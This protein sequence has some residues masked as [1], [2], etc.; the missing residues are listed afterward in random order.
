MNDILKSAI[1]Y[2]DAGLC[3]IPT[4]AD[5]RPVLKEWTTYQKNPPT[6]AQVK[7]WFS[8]GKRNIAAVCGAVSNLEVL[9]F[10]FKAEALKEWSQTVLEQAPGLFSKLIFEKSPKGAHIAYRVQGMTIPGNTKLA[11]KAVEVAGPGEH[12]YQGKTLKAQQVNGKWII[13]PELI[14][15]RGEGG[16]C[17]IYPSHGYDL[18][19]GSFADPPTITPEEREILIEAARA[20]NS[21]HPP[22]EVN[23]GLSINHQGGKLPGQD[24]DERGDLR[25]LLSKHGWTS[26]GNGTDGREK[27]ARPGKENGKA[28]SATLTDGRIFYVFSSNAYPFEAGRAY[29]PFGVYAALEHGGDFSAAGKAL[30]GQGYGDKPAPQG[31]GRNVKFMTVGAMVKEFGKRIEWLWRDH[32]PKG[33]PVIYAGREG[34]GKSSNVAQICKEVVEEDPGAWVIWVG[35]EGF[36]SDHADKWVKLGMPDRV[37]MLSDNN[38]VYKLQLDSYKDRE[39]LDQA[40][41]ELKKE[42]DGHVAAVVIDSIRGMQSLGENDPKLASVISQINSI[43]CDKHKASCIYIAHHK[44]GYDANRLNKVAGSTGITSS[45]RAVYAVERVSEFVCKIIP[46]KSNALGHNPKTYRSVLIE[47]DDEG[48]DIS[49]VEDVGQDDGTMKTKAERLLIDLFKEQSEYRTREIWEKG[50]EQGISKETLKKAKENLPIET[51]HETPKSPWIWRCSLYKQNVSPWEKTEKSENEK[52]NEINQGEQG[53]Q[54]LGVPPKKATGRT[55]RTGRIDEINSLPVEKTNNSNHL[56]NLNSS[57][58]QY[59]RETPNF[60]TITEE[61]LDR[62]I[63]I[64]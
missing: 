20:C 61:D 32:I 27:W 41:T 16:Y 18:K 62:G 49:I 10:D 7:E 50:A 40:L 55:G 60:E 53:E 3:I 14:E 33:N 6:E 22:H 5:K 13:I 28:S 59:T 2:I 12:E 34:S 37:V 48:Y 17:L 63:E 21:F 9:D 57:I 52:P 35:T 1:S 51:I 47:N 19:Q 44:K 11:R 58:S 29:G 26:K 46:D 43:V 39:F 64:Q 30:A 54:N 15:T 4:G 23:Q 31:K 8:N 24:Y 56:A 25:G 36:I 38:G 45:V 42:T